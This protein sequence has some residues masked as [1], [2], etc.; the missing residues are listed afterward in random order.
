MTEWRQKKGIGFVNRHVQNVGN[1]F[2]LK[3]DFQRFAV[4]TFAFADVAFNINVRKK[5]HFDFGNAVAFAGF[6]ASAGHVERKASGRIA[7]GFGFRQVGK[8][9]ADMGKQ[10]RISG[11]IGTRRPTDW[12]LV[13]VD[14]LVNVFDAD[15]FVVFSGRFAAAVDF[16]V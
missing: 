2:V 15:E 11:W 4:K 14:N 3:F 12:R 9:V 8:P 10:A 7:A 6:A 13:Y 5:V 1:G 16:L